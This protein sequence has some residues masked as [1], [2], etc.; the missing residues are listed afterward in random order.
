VSKMWFLRTANVDVGECLSAVAGGGV[1]IDPMW[2][3][4]LA[5]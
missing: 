1:E 5:R 2:S 4:I 3:E